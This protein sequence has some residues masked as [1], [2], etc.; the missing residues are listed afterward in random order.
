MLGAKYLSLGT[1]TFLT[2]GGVFSTLIRTR[3]LLPIDVM[4]WAAKFGSI[5]LQLPQTE[6]S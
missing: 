5:K 2:P 3:P 1:V 4:E 6:G